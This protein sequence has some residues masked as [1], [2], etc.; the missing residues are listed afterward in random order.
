MSHLAPSRLPARSPHPRGKEP[1]SPPSRRRFY[2]NYVEP[3]MGSSSLVPHRVPP[4]PMALVQTRACLIFTGHNP[5]VNIQSKQES[6]LVQN[7]PDHHVTSGLYC[8]G[9]SL[10]PR[11][12]GAVSEVTWT[13]G[14]PA[15]G[16]GLSNLWQ[17]LKVIIWT[18]S[19]LSKHAFLTS[20]QP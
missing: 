17:L 1:R 9:S 4:S 20:D 19:N 14:P 11:A 3:C 2:T 15:Q 5:T 13:F 7:N 10:R 8:D 6:L 18:L 16:L 12:P